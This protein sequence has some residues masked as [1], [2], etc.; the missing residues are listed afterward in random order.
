MWRAL[1]KLTGVKLKIL[2]LYHPE[3]DSAS[4][5][6]NKTVNQC[7]RFHVGQNKKGWVRALP[8]IRFDMMNTVNVSTGFSGFQLKLGRS[9]RV[10]PPLVPVN[11]PD[12]LINT[13][14][15]VVALAVVERVVTDVAEAKDNLL[16]A[17]VAQADSVNVSR[18]KEVAHKVGDL[19]MLSM[20][21]H[22]R[23]YKHKG[24]KPVAKFMP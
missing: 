22:R 17:K 15:A 5:R 9:P 16:S 18:G 19:V 8:Q 13:P 21:N 10:I 6:S 20:L 1:L 12:D 24:E 2:S 11:L 7:V 4:E 23:D 3:S 14:E